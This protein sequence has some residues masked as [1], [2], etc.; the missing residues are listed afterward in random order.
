MKKIVSA[1]LATTM[2]V[3]ATVSTAHAVTVY[4]DP[5]RVTYVD[6]LEFQI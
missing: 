1:L 6:V 4:Q 2:L 5:D 3:S